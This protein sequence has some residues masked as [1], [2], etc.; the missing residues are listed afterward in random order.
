MTLRTWLLLTMSG[1]GLTMTAH[2]D[3]E[4]L[5][6]WFEDPFFQVRNGMVDCPT[7]LGPFT[8]E[9]VKKQESHWR[10]ERGTSCWIAGKCRLP[11]S[12]YYDKDIAAAVKQTF[13]A[14]TGFQT[15]SIWLMFQRRF[16]WIEGCIA[17]PADAEA[18]KALVAATPDVE[19]VIVHLRSN[20]QA[21]LPYP[22][23]PADAVLQ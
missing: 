22:Q 5:K 15:D 10:V 8:N 18:L 16:V 14:T 3:P 19:E 1:L 11:N 23:I 7:P 20:P 12:Y 6:N 21:P 13:D 17:N 4:I 2:A 9:T